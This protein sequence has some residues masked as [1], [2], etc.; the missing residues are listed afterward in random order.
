MRLKS[1]LST[2]VGLVGL[3][4][5]G[6]GSAYAQAEAAPPPPQEAAPA[7]GPE[8][9]QMQAA[10]PEQGP[11]QQDYPIPP[12]VQGAAVRLRA[13]RAFCFGGPHPA[14]CGL[15]GFARTPTFTTTRPSILRLLPAPERLLLLHRRPA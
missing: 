11:P 14:P 5:A 7:P 13:G 2:L 12:D 9:M 3:G 8:Q 15:G 6:A 10:A 4:F 1:S